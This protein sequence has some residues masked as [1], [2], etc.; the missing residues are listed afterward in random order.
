METCNN[1][2]RVKM[3]F[4]SLQNLVD[5]FSV[6][7]NVISQRLALYINK[8][9]HFL[10]NYRP[11]SLTNTDYKIIAFIFARRLQK[12]IDQQIGQGQTWK[13]SLMN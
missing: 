1:Q 9:K 4:S 5:K 12:I 6:R 7:R 10:K 3:N 8:M 2:N 13:V 11:F